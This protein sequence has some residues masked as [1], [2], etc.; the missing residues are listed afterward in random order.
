M[1]EIR[2]QNCKVLHLWPVMSLKL[3]QDANMLDFE[4]SV[5]H[6]YGLRVFGAL[7][8]RTISNGG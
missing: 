4:E 2:S 6:F 5:Y 7:F 1:V 8:C 3:F